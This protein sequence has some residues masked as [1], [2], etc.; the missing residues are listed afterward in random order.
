M[1]IIFKGDAI[2][3]MDANS[4]RLYHR[5]RRYDAIKSAFTTKAKTSKHNPAIDYTL[6]HPAL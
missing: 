6:T 5:I 2:L 3:R 1:K 4:I